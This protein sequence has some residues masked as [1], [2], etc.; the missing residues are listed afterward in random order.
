MDLVPKIERENPST[1][2]ISE[3]ILPTISDWE[4]GKRYY[5]KLAAECKSISKGSMYDPNSK[6]EVRADF[7]VSGAQS[8]EVDDKVKR[9]VDVVKSAAKK[10][11]KKP[12]AGKNILKNG[13]KKKAKAKRIFARALAKTK[14]EGRIININI[15]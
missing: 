2:S 7:Q 14:D 12:V 6:S 11:T 8:I 13:M 3:H 5:I 15:T 1:L 10:A 9:K 4:V